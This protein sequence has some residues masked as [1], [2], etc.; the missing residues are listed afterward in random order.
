MNHLLIALVLANLSANAAN[1][2]KLELRMKKRDWV[3]AFTNKDEAK[4]A[5]LLKAYKSEGILK[6]MYLEELERGHT[7][8]STALDRMA[9]E[10]GAATIDDGNQDTFL[11]LIVQCPVVKPAIFCSSRNAEKH[12][13]CL[14]AFVK[15]IDEEIARVP[16]ILGFAL[17]ESK[18]NGQFPDIYVNGITSTWTRLA[19]RNLNILSARKEEATTCREKAGDACNRV[20]EIDALQNRGSAAYPGIEKELNKF[21][22]TAPYKKAVQDFKTAYPR[23][24]NFEAKG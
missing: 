13:T 20:T 14:T 17:T 7:C 15:S 9:I 22:K 10:G 12:A 19:A 4:I 3:I 11:H 8:D 5:S 6:A 2:K 24:W 23:I 1:D 21:P 16:E 18:S